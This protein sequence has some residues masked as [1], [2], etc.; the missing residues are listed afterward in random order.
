MKKAYSK[1]PTTTSGKK[2]TRIAIVLSTYNGETFLSELLDSLFEQT[3]T[4][5]DLWVRDDGSTDRTVEILHTKKKEWE[6]KEADHTFT[7]SSGP[8]CGPARSFLHL[9]STV[10]G[11]YEAYA[12][13]DQD[14]IWLKNK[15]FK[16]KKRL[17]AHRSSYGNIP[18]MYHTGFSYTGSDKET[19]QLASEPKNIGF[20]NAL[21]QN[22]VT[23]CTLIIDSQ[24]RE[25]VLYE[26]EPFVSDD[27][28]RN[29]CSNMNK[30]F[31]KNDPVDHIIMHDWWVYLIGTA[32]GNHYYDPEPS[33]IFRRHDATATPASGS[34]FDE[35]K[36]RLKHLSKR[37]F[38]IQHIVDQVRLFH[39]LFGP[40][41]HSP[42]A[43]RLDDEQLYLMQ[44]LIQENSNFLAK[45]RHFF[46]APY[47]RSRRI[48]TLMF[49]FLMFFTK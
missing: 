18:F 29:H 43:P 17:D 38:S 27:Y 37:S 19:T 14:D 11:I 26:I 33:L 48:E 7:I 12:F 21:V 34:F 6:E 35:Y 1:E 9:L 45:V 3:Y 8:N 16:A 40:A 23:G 15:L 10:P 5:W 46:S 49:R 36:G 30:E 24:L 20:S 42:E 41:E 13:C 31:Q 28:I 25:L 39:A 47:K 2:A 4:D 32:F 44:P 22:Q